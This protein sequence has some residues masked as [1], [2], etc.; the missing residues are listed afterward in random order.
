MSP[1]PLPLPCPRASLSVARAAR[2][3]GRRRRGAPL[4]RV[5]SICIHRSY[6][7]KY[8]RHVHESDNCHSRSVDVSINRAASFLSFAARGSPARFLSSRPLPTGFSPLG[9]FSLSYFRET[10]RA[11]RFFPALPSPDPRGRWARTSRRVL[12]KR[13]VER[14]LSRCET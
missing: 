1:L 7:I 11:L 5:R 2:R 14:G 12:R 10:V 13:S 3:C 8:T 6:G 9:H 4:S